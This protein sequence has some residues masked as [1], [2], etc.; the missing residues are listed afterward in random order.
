M[1]QISVSMRSRP[2]NGSFAKAKV[3]IKPGRSD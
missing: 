2:K 1:R 3:G